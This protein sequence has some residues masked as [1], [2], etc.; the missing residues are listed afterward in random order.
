MEK[1]PVE[2][3]LRLLGMFVFVLEALDPFHIPQINMF[4]KI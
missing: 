3:S 1:L 4:S 2:N